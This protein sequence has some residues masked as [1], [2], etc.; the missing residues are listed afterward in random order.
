VFVY[1]STVNSSIF[2]KSSHFPFPYFLLN[3][4]VIFWEIFLLFMVKSYLLFIPFSHII[5]LYFHSNDDE[6]CFIL[7]MPVRGI[8]NT[9]REKF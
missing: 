6:I 8:I 7:I 2:G 1:L 3:I 5:I 9:S 4:S